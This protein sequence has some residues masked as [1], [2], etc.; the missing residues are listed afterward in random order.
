VPHPEATDKL[1][2]A[3]EKIVARNVDKRVAA[4]RGAISVVPTTRQDEVSGSELSILS[5]ELSSKAKI[6]ANYFAFTQKCYI[7]QPC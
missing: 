7:M 6:F 5:P 4:G 3:P 1:N 2:L